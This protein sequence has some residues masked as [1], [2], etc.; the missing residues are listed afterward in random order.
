MTAVIH[1][2]SLCLICLL[3]QM[4]GAAGVQ[5]QKADRGFSYEQ[6]RPS[7][8]LLASERSATDP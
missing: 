8:H 7:E 1:V 2:I 6:A 4:Q 3:L 5:E